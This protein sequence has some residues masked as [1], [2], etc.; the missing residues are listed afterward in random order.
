MNRK[1]SKRKPSAKDDRHS[2]PQAATSAKPAS[3]GSPDPV[4]SPATGPTPAMQ[5][6][7]SVWL[8]FHLFAILVSFT[9]VVEPS[10]IQARLASV[11]HPYL[12]A[13]H[14]AADDRPVYLAHGDSSEQPHRLQVTTSSLTDIDAVN[15]VSWQTVGPDHY[16]GLAVSDRVAR[17]LSTAAT[18]AENDQP[19]LVA[20]LLLP[21]VEDDSAV[22][23]I[24]I[25]R[26]P[27]DL[28]DINAEA[29]SA[30][31]ARVIRNGGLVS[32]VQLNPARLSSQA[33]SDR[34]KTPTQ[35]D[36]GNE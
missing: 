34:L 20:E 15:T 36:Q 5:N 7:L 2:A 29:E 23:A 31:V 27:T 8:L 16:A 28:N 6:C 24:R 1:K 3:A 19:S 21:I 18:L 22:S 33:V 17:W 35:E 13:F 14:F 26:W 11:V 25:V 10:T 9:S 32:L 30:Y 4:E 12:Q